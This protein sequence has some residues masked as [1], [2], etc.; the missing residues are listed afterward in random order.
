[1]DSIDAGTGSQGSEMEGCV[2]KLSDGDQSLGY[3]A[4]QPGS[5]R[6]CGRQKQERTQQH[7]H[8]T[9]IKNARSCRYCDE[10]GEKGIARDTPEIIGYERKRTYLGCCRYAKHTPYPLRKAMGRMVKRTEQRHKYDDGT[11]CSKRHLETEVE[12]IE[13]IP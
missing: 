10:S 2:G 8:A 6:D 1:M 3:P 13:R 11:Y 4:C 7:Q 5:E 9:E 12:E